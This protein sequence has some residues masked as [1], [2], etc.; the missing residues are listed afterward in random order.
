M[1]RDVTASVLLGDRRVG[2]LGYHKGN[3]WFDYEDLSADHPVLGQG[4]ERDP[5]RRRK[6]S[7]AVPEWFAG[8]LPEPGSGLRQLVASSLGK[9]RIHDFVLLCHVGGDLPGAVCVVPDTPLE[10]LPDHELR[11]E[12]R[13]EHALKFSFAGVQ[14]KFSMRYEGK[15]LVLPATGQGGDWW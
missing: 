3:T 11:E 4:F 9:K 2:T 13:H 15:A 1:Q 10:K 5:R 8:L 7:G 14:P 6:A 12:C